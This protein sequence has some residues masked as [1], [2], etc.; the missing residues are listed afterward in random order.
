M[1]KHSMRK[2]QYQLIVLTILFFSFFDASQAQNLHDAIGGGFGGNEKTGKLIYDGL[3]G[4]LPFF[5][6]KRDDENKICYLEN[7]D[8]VVKDMRKNFAIVQYPCPDTDPAHNNVYWDGEKDAVN[9]GFSPSNDLLYAATI[10]SDMFK[11]W[12]DT[13]VLIENGKPKQLVVAINF[14]Q[15]TED[16]KIEVADATDGDEGKLFGNGTAEFYPPTSLDV[17]AHELS[18]E[19]TQ[20]HSGLRPLTLMFPSA[21]KAALGEQS[22]AL[23]ESFADMT[24]QAAEFFV[25]GH[26]DWLIGGGFP[27]A[28]GKALRYMDNP[29]RDCLDKAPGEDCSIENMKLIINLHGKEILPGTYYIEH[30]YLA[31]IFNKAFYLLSSSPG[32]DTHMAYNV[33]VKANMYFWASNTTFSEAACGVIKATRQY[34]PS[35]SVDNVTEAF[36][37]VGIDT[38]Q[39]A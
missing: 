36:D 9:G 39:C 30:H 6:I 20:Q 12:Y 16:D 31:G 1:S 33:M 23:N 26:N 8:V 2:I 15:G 5:I 10:V 34:Y 24:G 27:K 19:F 7:D 13:S 11:K 14:Y 38:R 17:V 28:N 18:H 35:Y 32:W 25:T 29:S 22:L 3:P 37:L 21:Q 4:H